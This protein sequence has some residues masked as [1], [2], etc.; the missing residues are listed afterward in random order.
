MFRRLLP[1]V[2]ILSF[3]FTPI[4]ML[5]QDVTE[6]PTLEVSTPTPE[7]TAVPTLPPTEEP[8]P[9]EPPPEETPVTTPEELLGQLFSLLKDAVYIAWASA[10]VVVIVGLLKSVFKFSGQAAVFVTL[11]VEVLIW[12]GYAIANYFGAGEAFQRGYLIG[13][14][15]ARSLL[16][17]FGTLFGAQVL[18]KAA[19][20]RQVPVAGYRV[21][22]PLF[23][24]ANVAVPERSDRY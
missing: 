16:P 2:M 24:A 10:G 15:I 11:A 9:V 14:D 22:E 21:P 23:K 17:L 7:V 8:P 5:A 19:A 20:K 12:L 13:V 6:E 4:V 1:I 18:Y 3:T